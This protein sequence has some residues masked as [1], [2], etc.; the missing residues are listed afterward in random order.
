[1][2]GSELQIMEEEGD[3]DGYSTPTSQTIRVYPD[4]P[5]PPPR[6]KRYKKSR[7]MGK[8]LEIGDS[9]LQCKTLLDSDLSV[10]ARNCCRLKG[11]E[12]V[13][14]RDWSGKC[15]SC[16]YIGKLRPG[17]TICFRLDCALNPSNSKPDRGLE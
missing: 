1:M 13:S 15:S 16:G 4:R 10:S 17:R 2:W 9:E 6:K 3:E 7:R 8:N 11:S 5:P 14:R 12:N